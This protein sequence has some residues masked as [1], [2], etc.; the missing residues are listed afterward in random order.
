MSEKVFVDGLICKRHEKAPEYVL[1]NLSVKASEF[2]NWLAQNQVNGWVNI[3]VKRS[4][5]GKLYA[6]LD[7]FTP[8]RADQH[9][10]GMES[11]KAAAQ[12]A[13]GKAS[14]ANLDGFQDS[15]I[16]F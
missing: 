3:A 4:Q 1:V 15:D 6:E 10:A 8:N 14:N 12:P 13:K 5:A 16:P 9:A 2:T 7:T 11:V